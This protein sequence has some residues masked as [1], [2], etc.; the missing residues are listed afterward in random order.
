MNASFITRVGQKK[1]AGK[2]GNGQLKIAWAPEKIARA[3][4]RLG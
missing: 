3:A 4:Q 2:P 1:S